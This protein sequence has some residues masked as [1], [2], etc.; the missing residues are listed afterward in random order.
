MPIKISDI[1][2]QPHLDYFNSMKPHQLDHGGRAG[3]KSSK[4][5]IKIALKLLDDPTCEVVVVRQDYTDHRNSTFRDLIT[6]FGRLGVKLIA[7]KHY[8][9]GETG[10]MWIKLPQGNYVHFGQM[11]EIDKLKGWRPHNDGNQIKIVWFF[12]ITEFKEERYITEARSGFVRGSKDY[13]LFLYE[14]NDA[15]KL[16]HWTYDFMKKMSKREDAYVL[17]TNY[18]DA[19]EWQQKKFLG[20]MMLK[21]I[22]MLK[23]TDP[24]QFKSVYLGFPANLSGTVFKQFNAAKHVEAPQKDYYDITIG[25]DYGSNDATVFTATGIREEYQHI[26]VVKTYYHKNGVS[27]GVKNIND[28]VSDFVVF[29]KQLNKLYPD[30]VFTVQIDTANKSFYDLVELATMQLSYIL[31]EPLP[32]MKKRRTTNKK[33]SVIQERIDV[34]EVM[35]GAGYVSINSECTELIK[36]LEEAEYDK[37]GDLKDDGTTDIDSIDSWWYSWIKDMDL[38]WE[39]IVEVV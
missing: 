8:P 37:N 13:M 33:K 17:K 5:A 26:D 24:E 15:P 39:M 12:E 34:S 6:A 10:A 38:I 21:E 30:N 27:V 7:G 9:R 23:K 2:A 29:A 3:Y 20:H 35:F 31:L 1:V 36:A 19:P 18:N 22:E 14:W 25:C 32:K 28:Y 11:K 16:S 4:N